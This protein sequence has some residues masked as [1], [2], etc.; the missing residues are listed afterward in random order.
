MFNT[1]DKLLAETVSIKL[2]LDLINGT[3]VL[4]IFLGTS[5]DT[6]NTYD[7]IPM[8]LLLFNIGLTI[9][10]IVLYDFPNDNNMSLVSFITP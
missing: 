4:S 5:L 10:A 2:S 7:L 8:S 3:Y 1:V 6:C 9:G